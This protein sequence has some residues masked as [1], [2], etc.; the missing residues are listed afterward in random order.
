MRRKM[1][2]ITI[3][4]LS[5]LLIS[6]GK[7]KESNRIMDEAKIAFA[8]K[9]YEKAEG[10]LKLAKDEKE[11]KEA[12]RLYEQVKAF[13]EIEDRVSSM[14]LAN[15]IGNLSRESAADGFVY[16]LD[17]LKIVEK[18]KTESKLVTDEL[19]EYINEVRSNITELIKIFKNSVQEGDLENAERYFQYIRRI[20]SYDLECLKDYEFNISEYEKLLKDAKTAKENEKQENADDLYEWGPGVK[21]K[22]EEDI[23]AKGYIDSKTNI[24]YKKNNVFNNQGYYEVYTKINGKEAYVVN[25][26]VKTGNYHA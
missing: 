1:K 13:R 10:I 9:E 14:N 3:L 26:N 23:I 21:E 16:V 25:V 8:S 4:I 22:F 6:C 24:I 12:S 19:S 5:L 7:A 2:I 11:T 15:S 17:N 20:E 18:N